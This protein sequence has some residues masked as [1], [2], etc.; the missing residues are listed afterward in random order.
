MKDLRYAQPYGPPTLCSFQK[1]LGTRRTCRVVR[2][3]EKKKFSTNF[4]LNFV[5]DNYLC[6]FVS[7]VPTLYDC[8]TSF[9]SERI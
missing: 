2:L 8:Q 7:A 6:E 4:K 3:I 1:S 9:R 5:I